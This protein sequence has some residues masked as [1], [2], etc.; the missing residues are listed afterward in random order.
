MN[1]SSPKPLLS[2]SLLTSGK[3]KE[4]WKCLDSLNGI[5]KQIPTELIIVDTGC[6]KEIKEKL[7]E[8]TDHIVSFPWCNDFSK[9]RNAG[10][11]EAKG[12]WFLYLDDDEWFVETKDLINFFITGEYKSYQS[13]AYITRNYY[14]F[15]EKVYEDNAAHRVTRITPDIMFRGIIHEHF[16]VAL[17]P[18]K[19]LSSMVK[20]YGY[21]FT[22]KEERDAHANRNIT[23]IKKV[24]KEEKSDIRNWIHL[25]QE[26]Y[27]LEEYSILEKE[28]GEL[29]ERLKQQDNAYVNR[30]RPAIY[31]GILLSLVKQEKTKEAID[32]LLK[33]RSDN[34]NTELSIARMDTIAVD[35]YFQNKEYEKVLLHAKNYFKIRDYYN[36][37]EEEKYEQYTFFV[38]EVFKKEIEENVLIKEILSCIFV[39]DHLD[40][41]KKTEYIEWEECIMERDIIREYLLY[42]SENKNEKGK[43]LFPHMIKNENNKEVIVEILKDMEKNMDYDAL[44]Y[45]LE[46]IKNDHHYF[47]YIKIR[48]NK[49]KDALK[50]E[51][52][53]LFQKV[54]DFLLLEDDIY[55][56][57]KKNRIDLE[58]IFLSIP[59][60]AWKKA[61]DMLCLYADHKKIENILS[62]MESSKTKENIRWDYLLLKIAEWRVRYKVES[63]TYEDTKEYLEDFIV[64]QIDFYSK[65]YKENVIHQRLEL[66]PESLLLALELKAIIFSGE[67]TIPKLKLCME[68]CIDVYPPCDIIIQHFVKMAANNIKKANSVQN[69]MEALTNGIKAQ[70]IVLMNEGRAEEAKSILQQLK[71]MVPYDKEVEELARLLL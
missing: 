48:G 13:A 10:L 5:R 42:M 32:Y 2:I 46:D 17:Q 67:V 23:L 11:K 39:N 53:N 66:L 6:E 19:H 61:A 36:K 3:K 21:I 58:K 31:L 16:S 18:Q 12:E 24:L 47:S 68:K 63:L 26:Y 62:V 30:H 9:A 52:E 38:K 40:T 69:E 54:E 15:D 14:D 1:Y 28:S 43:L 22:S 65:I 37:K 29:I 44:S 25:F 33:I 8:Y 7:K 50:E 35:L 45:L 64:T 4:L 41:V 20:H 57:A 59:Y 70:I 60:K 49:E 71:R 51:Y 55:K 27:Y 56:I 34:R